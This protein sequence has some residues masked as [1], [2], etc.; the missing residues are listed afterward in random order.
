MK[1]AREQELRWRLRWL[2]QQLEATRRALK[3]FEPVQQGELV[4]GPAPAPRKLSRQQEAYAEYVDTRRTRLDELEVDAPDEAPPPVAF[5]N[6]SLKK[7]VDACKDDRQYEQL[8]D[9]FFALDWP[10]RM[11]TPYPF[12][13]FAKKWPEL[14]EQLNRTPAPNGDGR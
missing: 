14:L 4:P 6:S 11:E 8:L 13:A 7:V 3:P 1:S 10:A 5:I 2:E 12:N 9:L